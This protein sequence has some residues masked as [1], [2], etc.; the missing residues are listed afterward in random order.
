M[1]TSKR[2]LELLFKNKK[3]SK[4]SRFIKPKLRAEFFYEISHYVNSALD[5]SDGLFFELERL[6]KVNKIGFEFLKE[7]GKDIGCSGEEYEMLF[8]IKSKYKNLVEKIAK[9]H[10]K[11]PRKNWVPLANPIK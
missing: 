6:S 10:I 4:K 11:Y 7:I 1:G 9:T 8:S 5:I 3:I 2:D